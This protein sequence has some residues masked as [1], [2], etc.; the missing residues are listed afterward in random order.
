M[1]ERLKLT[2]AQRLYLDR[3]R[4][5]PNGCPISAHSAHYGPSIRRLIRRQLVS[6][7]AHPHFPGRWK[8]ATI[9]EAGRQALRGGK[10]A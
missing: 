5:W 9:T 7:R 1:A 10:D 6:L 3:V 2:K 8:L 4:I